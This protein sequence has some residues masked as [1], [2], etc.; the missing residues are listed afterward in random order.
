MYL[1]GD[2]N[3]SFLVDASL[4]ELV[5]QPSYAMNETNHTGSMTELN[6]R[7]LINNSTELS[8]NSSSVVVGS[9]GNEISFELGEVPP[10]IVPY[11]VTFLGSLGRNDTQVFVSTTELLHLPRRTDGGSVTR[12]DNLHGGLS[13]LKRNETVWSLVFPY[14]YYGK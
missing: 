6:I 4:S 8:L 11:S 2:L 3:A 14:T 12:L 5:G 10:S 7:V 9:S 13:V 1:E